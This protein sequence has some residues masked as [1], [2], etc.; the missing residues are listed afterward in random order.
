MALKGVSLNAV[1]VAGPGEAITPDSPKRGN[2]VGISFFS[3]GSPATISLAIEGTI[4]GIV[5]RVITETIETSEASGITASDNT[6][7][8]FTAFRAN[9]IAL[10]GGTDPTVTATLAILA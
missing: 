3:T 10:T 8:V 7:L 5:W 6:T 2:V 4:D 9:L 1:T